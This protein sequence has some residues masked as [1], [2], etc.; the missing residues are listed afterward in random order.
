MSNKVKGLFDTGNAQKTPVRPATPEPEQKAPQRS[1]PLKRETSL[2]REQE[3]LYREIQYLEELKKESL[4][5]KKTLA[6]MRKAEEDPLVAQAL[7]WHQNRQGK[8]P[9]NEILDNLK[10]RP[11]NGEERLEYIPP[12]P[13]LPEPVPEPDS[14]LPSETSTRVPSPV[15]MPP[16][17]VPAPVKAAP[18]EIKDPFQDLPVPKVQKPKTPRP[19]SAARKLS[20]VTPVLNNKWF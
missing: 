13:K 17:P 20:G 2:T 12:V 4:S 1:S 3:A 7:L 10:G 18:V 15:P 8:H 14:V 6:S 9:R 16:T 19:N 11:K 5:R